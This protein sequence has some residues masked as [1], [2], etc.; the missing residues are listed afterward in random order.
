MNFTM[1]DKDYLFVFSR[2]DTRWF[3]CWPIYYFIFVII[4]LIFQ[5]IN[6]KIST[7]LNQIY[8]LNHS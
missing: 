2:F 4:I 5:V 6:C 3:K 8:T 7:S 1:K